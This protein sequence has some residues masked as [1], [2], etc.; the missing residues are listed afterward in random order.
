MGTS[1]DTL[2]DEITELKTIL[3]YIEDNYKEVYEEAE[4]YFINSLFE[5]E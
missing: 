2:I 3:Q 5:V 4:S 1:K